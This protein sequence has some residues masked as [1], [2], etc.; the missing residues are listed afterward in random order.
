[1]SKIDRFFTFVWMKIQMQPSVTSFILRTIFNLICLHGIITNEDAV[2][3]YLTLLDTITTFFTYQGSTP[4][5]VVKEEVKA[6][7]QEKLRTGEF[8]K[9]R[10]EDQ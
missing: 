7:V 2:P 3:V 1:M 10:K 8:E 5:P 4:N 9:V 6:Q